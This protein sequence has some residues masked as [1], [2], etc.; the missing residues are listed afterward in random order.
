[1]IFN[2]LAELSTDNL[3]ERNLINTVQLDYNFTIPCVNLHGSL[4]CH[5]W[6]LLRGIHAP[7]LFTLHECGTMQLFH[8]LW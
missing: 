3:Y 6:L 7:C 2:N 5:G 4:Q 1:M 8:A